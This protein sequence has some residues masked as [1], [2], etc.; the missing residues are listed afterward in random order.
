MNVTQWLVLSFVSPF[1]AL[2]AVQV[3]GMILEMYYAI[4]TNRKPVYVPVDRVVYKDRVV[5][6][7]RVKVKT[8]VVS[9]T[10]PEKNPAKAKKVTKT[11]Q[12]TQDKQIARDVVVGLSNLGFS[13]SDAKILVS[14]V[15]N[16]KTY[17]S[18]DTLFQDCMVLMSEMRT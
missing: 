5:Y 17:N 13:K 7:D 12:P 15:T 18:A 3:M 6:R 8:K 1:V 16:G 4:Q 2:Y 11:K 10:K 14:K 9:A